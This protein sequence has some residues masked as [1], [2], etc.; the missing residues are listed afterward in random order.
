MSYGVALNSPTAKGRREYRSKHKTYDAAARLNFKQ[1]MLKQMSFDQKI[2]DDQ[3]KSY[4]GEASFKM[5]ITEGERN[6]TE[7]RARFSIKDS[8]A[9]T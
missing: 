6:K 3:D 7:K 8:H 5:R 1:S 2:S 9:N 4:S